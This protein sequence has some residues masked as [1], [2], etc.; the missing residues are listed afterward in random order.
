MFA[1]SNGTS[2]LNKVK[3][4]WNQSLVYLLTGQVC[5]RFQEIFLF[6]WIKK[7]KGVL[8]LT[9]LIN[10]F[11]FSGGQK[12]VASAVEGFKSIVFSLDSVSSETVFANN[13]KGKASLYYR[14]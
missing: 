5:L 2:D 12:S 11:F 3:N 1:V 10:R 6:L 8:W 13:E 7:L 9:M 14:T 4:V